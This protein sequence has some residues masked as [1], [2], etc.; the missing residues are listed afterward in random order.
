MMLQR[1][2]DMEEVREGGERG[3]EGEMGREGCI[4]Q[5]EVRQKNTGLAAYCTL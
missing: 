4:T 1:N 2:Y 3:W 5:R